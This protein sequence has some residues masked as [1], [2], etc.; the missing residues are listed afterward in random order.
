VNLL[1]TG[2][3]FKKSYYH[4]LFWTGSGAAY[5]HPDW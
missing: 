5:P 1:C 3:P 2:N 4:C